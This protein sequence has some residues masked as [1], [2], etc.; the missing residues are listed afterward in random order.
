MA[1]VLI[2]AVTGQLDFAPRA[3]LSNF[4]DYSNTGAYDAQSQDCKISYK[5]P[6]MDLIII[7]IGAT[8]SKQGR[9]GSVVV[10]EIISDFSNHRSRE[11]SRLALKYR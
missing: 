6:A 8:C 9:W 1:Q 3:A 5:N 4:T 10:A 11:I 2:N 7:K